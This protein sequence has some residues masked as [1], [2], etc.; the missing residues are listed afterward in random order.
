MLHKNKM[1]DKGRILANFLVPAALAVALPAL[2][3]DSMEQLVKECDGC[4]GVDGVSQW[5]DMPTIAGISEFVHS[6]ALFIYQDR[7][8]PCAQSEYRIGDTGRPATDM[9]AIAEKMT[10]SQMEEIAAY[11]AAKPFVPAN[12]DFD[13]ALAEQGRK[14]HDKECERC[15]TDGGANPDDDA[16][17]LKGQWMGY[18]RHT[19]AEYAS[20]ERDQPKRM[21]EK[22]DALTE[23]DTEALLNYYASPD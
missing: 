22:M 11:Y 13:A 16:S 19:F 2:A 8:R 21:K 23:E 7:A 18:M 4:H 1:L 9:C 20:G 3:A 12:Q 6:D 15:H 14:V 10:E 17:I 5:D